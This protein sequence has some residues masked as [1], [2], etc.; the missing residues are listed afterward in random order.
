MGGEAKPVAEIDSSQREFERMDG[1]LDAA[2]VFAAGA[3]YHQSEGEPDLAAACLS[4]AVNLY[5]KV[6]GGFF[7]A[8]LTG[9]QRQALRAK[10]LRVR[11]IIKGLGPPRRNEAA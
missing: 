4:D 6:L 2:L 7:R 3:E 5:A 1:E 11:Q 10:L 9:G 8:D